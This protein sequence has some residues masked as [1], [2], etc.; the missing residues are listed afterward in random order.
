M[1]QAPI[2]IPGGVVH[3]IHGVLFG[4]RGTHADF[5]VV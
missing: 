5:L 2:F 4:E 3:D 1:R